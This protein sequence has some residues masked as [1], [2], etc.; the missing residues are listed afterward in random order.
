MNYSTAKTIMFFD[1]KTS[2]FP[3]LSH[4]LSDLPLSCPRASFRESKIPANI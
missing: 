2:Q 3:S 1:R 4:S